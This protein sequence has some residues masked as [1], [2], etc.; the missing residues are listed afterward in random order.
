MSHRQELDSIHSRLDDVQEG[1]LET[2]TVVNN[3]SDAQKIVR[4]ETSENNVDIAFIKRI[5]EVHGR[6]LNLTEP[7][8]EWQA[9]LNSI[10]GVDNE[11]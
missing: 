10:N 6:A 3:N 2:I 9:L 7:K 4:R 11:G 5:I 8:K 1:L